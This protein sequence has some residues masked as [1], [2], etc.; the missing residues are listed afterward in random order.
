MSQEVEDDIQK[1]ISTSIKNLDAQIYK[2]IKEEKESMKY[3][4]NKLYN[5]ILEL[6]EEIKF[7]EV[8]NKN[9]INMIVIIFVTIFAL[10]YKSLK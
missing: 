7:N 6:K 10:F 8:K 3:L 5:Q 2:Q 9:Y 4:I 1:E